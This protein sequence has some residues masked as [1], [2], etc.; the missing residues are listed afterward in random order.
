M[1]HSY[2]SDMKLTLQLHKPRIITK[3]MKVVLFKLLHCLI[4]YIVVRISEI[5]QMDFDITQELVILGEDC[6]NGD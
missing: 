1:R 3:V 4:E 2:I 6:D 5:L